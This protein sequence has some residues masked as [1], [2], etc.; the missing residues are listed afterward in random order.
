VEL[1]G[2]SVAALALAG[3]VGG[4]E[5]VFT[6]DDQVKQLAGAL[7]VV[8]RGIGPG[9]CVTRNMAGIGYQNGRLQ[10]ISAP[11]ATVTPSEP[12]GICRLGL[13][14]LGVGE[15]D[16]RIRIGARA[17]EIAIAHT[18]IAAVVPIATRN[19][20]EHV[21]PPP[22]QGLRPEFLF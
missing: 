21:K 2:A 3:A 6:G 16:I 22:H 11:A 10:N 7:H 13:A 17:I 4:G 5:Q 12:D 9:L 14:G 1:E 18:G 20:T 19:H 8:F 15:S